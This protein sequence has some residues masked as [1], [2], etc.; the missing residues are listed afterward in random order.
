M[1]VEQVDVVEDFATADESSSPAAVSPVVP[2]PLA[3]AAR[4]PGELHGAQSTATAGETV[5][6]RGDGVSP[7][8]AGQQPTSRA[9]SA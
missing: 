6:H 4:H 9:D 3:S 2:D 5:E 8:R 7:R 1:S